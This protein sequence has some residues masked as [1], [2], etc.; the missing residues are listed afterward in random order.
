LALV[1]GSS[2]TAING[3]D[4]S[5]T[6]ATM[7]PYARVRSGQMLAT[8]KIIPFAAP[9]V[10]VEA[11]ENLSAFGP[12]VQLAAFEPKS[13]ALIFSRLPG[14][15]ASLLEKAHKVIGARLESL[16][17]RIAWESHVA[18][19]TAALSWALREAVAKGA[20]LILV[21]GASAIVDRR[22]AIPA[23]IIAAGGIVENFGMPV[24]PG[25][26]LL[27]A[28]IG[29]TIVVGLPGCARS[30]K[31]NG[32][33][34]ILER[35]AANIPVDRD[36]IVAMGVGGLL[37]ETRRESQPHKYSRAR[38]SRSVAAI[39]LAAGLSSRM[40]RNK[41]LVELD[42]KPLVR[43][44]VETA[45]AS[46]VDTV[47]V[48][49][50]NEAEAIGASL[51]G[52]PVILAHNP[53][54]RAGLS[55]SLK[56]GIRALPTHIDGGLILLGDM[57][58]ISTALIDKLVDAF[59]PE[60]DCAICVAAY[61]GKRGNPVLWSRQY[62][63]DILALSG[64]NGAKHLIAKNEDKVCEVEASDEA[65]MVD[66]DTPDALTSYLERWK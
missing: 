66:I 53:D 26:L 10:L 18:H 33:D 35:L 20:D 57:P 41:L 22:D 37:H 31:L 19:E 6:L 1:N 42:G 17:S 49:T 45:L 51:Q 29:E 54:Y 55:A 9:R 13:A 21:L 36:D 52:L 38:K 7:P 11:A 46:A 3:L 39:V 14:T 16:G 40:G 5:I 28:R 50:G 47:I 59:D 24:E 43:R 25:N 48:V 62:F 30:P 60:E 2:I 8:I 34:F 27:L 32:F 12:P 61:E 4:E 65:P 44:V 58:A 63:P 64:D 23:A 56:A 15:P